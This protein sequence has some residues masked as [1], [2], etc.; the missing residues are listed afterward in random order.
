MYSQLL[1]DLDTVY[2][3]NSLCMLDVLCECAC[4]TGK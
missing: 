1:E 2:S 3:E 4:V